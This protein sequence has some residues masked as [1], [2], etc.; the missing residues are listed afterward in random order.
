M[1][2]KGRSLSDVAAKYSEVSHTQNFPLIC[3]AESLL[4]AVGRAVNYQARII[5][6]L[7]GPIPAVQHPGLV[8]LSF[9]AGHKFESAP[10]YVFTH[11]TKVKFT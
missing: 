2:E 5:V 7:L 3:S 6:P 1:L 10:I 8:Q 11:K 9:F 4:G